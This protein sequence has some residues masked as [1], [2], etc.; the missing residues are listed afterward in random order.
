M[1]FEFLL[2]FFLQLRIRFSSNNK[3]KTYEI[4]IAQQNIYASHY[5]ILLTQHRNDGTLQFTLFLWFH[6]FEE[7]KNCEIF[8]NFLFLR[9]APTM[10]I[11]SMKFPNLFHFLRIWKRFRCADKQTSTANKIEMSQCIFHFSVHSEVKVYDLK[12]RKSKRSATEGR[13]KE[14]KTNKKC[15]P[16]QTH[17][18]AVQCLN[19]SQLNANMLT[20]T[21][22]PLRLFVR[23]LHIC[24]FYVLA[25][26]M[27]CNW[28]AHEIMQVRPRFRLQF[29]GWINWV[30]VI[31]DVDNRRLPTAYQLN[32]RILKSVCIH[33]IYTVP[34]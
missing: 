28:H 4:S 6:L 30:E 25:I 19:Q 9:L 21:H 16:F 12:R 34:C 31:F 8:L 15:S 29:I 7:K 10:Q 18:K 5:F 23:S 3:R 33:T 1:R 20:Y 14:F 26:L 13:N 27:A 22:T 24:I 17:S 2:L 11:S 32:A